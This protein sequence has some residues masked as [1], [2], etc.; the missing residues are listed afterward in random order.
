[1]HMERPWNC[2]K[3]HFNCLLPSTAP[4]PH[5]YLSFNKWNKSCDTSYLSDPHL[6]QIRWLHYPSWYHNEQSSPSNNYK[7][8][9]YLPFQKLANISFHLKI[10]WNP[11]VQSK[12]GE[13]KV[14]GPRAQMWMVIYETRLKPASTLDIVWNKK[15]RFIIHWRVSGV[16]LL[17]FTFCC[18]IW[19]ECQSK[20]DEQNWRTDDHQCYYIICWQGGF[21]NLRWKIK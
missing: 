15:S 1:M 13:V 8:K 5:R 9:I 14:D 3:I 21:L 10:F 2:F 12:V 16:S 17:Q 6:E 11:R 19:G 7:Y 20:G 4:V 18:E